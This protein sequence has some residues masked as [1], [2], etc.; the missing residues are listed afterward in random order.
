MAGEIRHKARA[1]SPIATSRPFCHLRA[2]RDDLI[3]LA[4]LI[5]E[6]R[7]FQSIVQRC[8]IWPRSGCSGGATRCSASD[9][10]P[11]RQPGCG[12][13]QEASCSAMRCRADELAA[14]LDAF[15]HTF[16]AAAPEDEAHLC[17]EHEL[18]D[19]AQFAYAARFWWL[20]RRQVLR[21]PDRNA[22]VSL[23]SGAPG[24]G[25]PAFSG[26]RTYASAWHRRRPGWR[27][28]RPEGESAGGSFTTG[29]REAGCG[30]IRPCLGLMR[31]AAP[32][33]FPSPS[34]SPICRLWKTPGMIWRARSRT[35][36]P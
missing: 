34:L 13:L 25:F 35:S 29:P 27:N 7:A 26:P 8:R 23:W 28:S 33:F 15:A 10:Q 17:L 9:A 11:D 2:A 30:L 36:R 21:K 14:W 6:L 19:G 20:R 5:A 22:G 24:A 16:Y 31:E 1:A 4:A 3:A 32:H 12:C 18:I